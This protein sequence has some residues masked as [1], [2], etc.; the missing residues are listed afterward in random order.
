MHSGQYMATRLYMHIHA[1]LH[2]YTHDVV[3]NLV[4]PVGLSRVG[5]MKPA[6]DVSLSQSQS[7]G[8]ACRHPTA[9]AHAGQQVCL[10]TAMTGCAASR[11]QPCQTCCLAIP[12]PTS[13]PPT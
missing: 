3:R 8:K 7:R 11:R 12:Q 4:D 6:H 1:S 13:L 2:R 9:A 5:E 10:L